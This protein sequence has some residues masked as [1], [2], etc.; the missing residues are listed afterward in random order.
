MK[1]IG[2]KLWTSY[3]TMSLGKKMFLWINLY[4]VTMKH[5]DSMEDHMNTFNIVISHLLFID[6]NI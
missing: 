2:N 4:D 3:E 5:K 1:E 6:I